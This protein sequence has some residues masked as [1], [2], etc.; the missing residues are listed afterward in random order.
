MLIA[1]TG[2]A[3]SPGDH[4][5]AVIPISTP[6]RV[7]IN[8]NISEIIKDARFNLFLYFTMSALHVH[9]SLGLNQMFK[10][11]NSNNITFIQ[12][13]WTEYTLQNMRSEMSSTWY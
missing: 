9:K 6:G 4:W 7:L 2:V 11:Y 8:M 1:A 12:V 13:T 3:G 5:V 10:T